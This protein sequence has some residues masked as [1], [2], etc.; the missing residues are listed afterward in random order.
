M[1]ESRREIEL[2]L[3]VTTA[4]ADSV[5]Q[6]RE[7]IKRLADSGDLAAPAFQKLDAVLSRMGEQAK[8][9]DALGGLQPKL[10]AAAAGARELEAESKALGD[11]LQRNRA[12]T[13]AAGEQLARLK[14]EYQQAK[15]AVTASRA[16]LDEYRAGLTRSEQ[17]MSEHRA[18]IQLMTAAV[19]EAEK[20]VAEYRVRLAEA[21]NAV[22]AS[23]AEQ[24]QANAAYQASEAAVRGAAKELGALQREA[25]RAGKALAE[26][27]GGTRDAAT[28]QKALQDALV[29]TRADI[30][31]QVEITKVLAAS[32]K[33]MADTAARAAAE[34]KAAMA[35]MRAAAAA[36]AQGILSDYQRIEQAQKEAAKAAQDSKQAFTDAFGAL[37]GPNANAIRAEIERVRA[38]MDMLARSGALTGRELDAAMKQG[39]GTIKALERDLRAATGAVTLMDRASRLLNSTVGQVAAFLSLQEVARGTARAFYETV[40]GVQA[41]QA[42]LKAVYGSAGTAASQIETLKAAA[43]TSGLKVLD[44]SAA[45][46]KFSASTHAANIPLETSNELFTELTRVS[47]LLGLSSAKAEQALEAV[48]QMASKGTVSLEELR[49]QLGDALPGATSLAAKGLGLTTQELFKMVEAGALPAN[50]FIPALTK[51]LKT[52]EGTNETLRGSVAR[53]S[54]AITD[55]F[56]KMAEGSAVKSLT[57]GLNLL[58]T[59]MGTVV[60]VTYGM[61]KAFL[62]LKILNFVKGISSLTTQTTAA[63]TETARHTAALGANT[64]ATTANSAATTAAAT[65]KG[66]LAAASTAATAAVAASTTATTTLGGAMGLASKATGLMGAAASRLAMLAGGLPGVLA[67]VAV[68]AGALGTAI[69]EGA[70]KL[71]GYGKQLADNEAKLKAFDDAQKA[72]AAAAQAAANE[73]ALAYTKEITAADQKAKV[74]EKEAQAAEKNTQAVQQQAAAAERMVALR[75][76]EATTLALQVQNSELSIAAATKEANVKTELAATLERDLALR[77]QQYTATGLVNE[78]TEKELAAKAAVLEKARAE[79][80]QARATV[81]N[82]RAESTERRINANALKDNSQNIGMYKDAMIAARAEVARL[83]ELERQGAPVKDQ[84]AKASANLAVSTRGYADAVGDAVKQRDAEARL[85]D[86]NLQKSMAELSAREAQAQASRALGESLGDTNMV[87][88]AEITLKEIALERTRKQIEA[89]IENA[90]SIITV[91]KQKLDALKLQPDYDRAAAMELEATIKIA[92]A[93]IAEA[94]ARGIATQAAATEISKLIAGLDKARQANNTATKDMAGGWDRVTGSIGAASKKAEEFAANQKR[95]GDLYSRPGETA[96]QKKAEADRDRK[97]QE[98]D[99]AYMA[100]RFE[101]GMA[102]DTNGNVV[103]SVE[104]EDQMNQRV[105]RLF[106]EGAIGMTEAIKAA[107]LKLDL[108]EAA[109]YGVANVPGNH[110][111]YADTRREF[112]RLSAIVRASGKSGNGSV[113]DLPNQ[114]QQ[115]GQPSGGSGGAGITVNINGGTSTYGGKRQTLTDIIDTLSNARSRAS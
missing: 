97:K 71:M 72:S 73:R 11:T 31:A 65:A 70:A 115:G 14:V 33:H 3:Q 16:A 46:T 99:D 66:A 43:N 50:V 59:H 4:N 111:F 7:D 8:S 67:M 24:R 1:A 27:G 84:L 44:L 55:V 35:S 108:D 58:A 54:N 34:R 37:G 48:S 88:R 38:A 75:G 96:G 62:A 74:L 39:A 81:D 64:A 89:D 5:N 77:Q 49:Q 63:A 40:S 69:G 113:A 45:F 15:A 26:A 2:A 21:A 100:S 61:G 12:V 90:N 23:A 25:D 82:L 10:T 103:V 105:A 60:E 85:L 52:L 28:A 101:S 20:G 17:N 102:K 93:K 56:G 30:N 91:T 95:L 114:A 47:G 104:S 86:A 6:L 18:V 78:A 68:N 36:E 83:Q 51:A 98:Q 106:G 13:E 29:A 19:G 79:A 92:E 22:K 110:Q 80:V 87:R 57:S 76:E 94:K 53:V 32:D 112:E 107:N 41:L 9:L 109:K 42:G